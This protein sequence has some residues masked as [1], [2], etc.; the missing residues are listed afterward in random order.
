MALTFA[1]FQF[2]NEPLFRDLIH[3]QCF[4]YDN[5]FLLYS[6]SHKI[7]VHYRT[8]FIRNT[9]IL[10]WARAELCEHVMLKELQ[11]VFVAFARACLAVCSVGFNW[12]VILHSNVNIFLS[13]F[14]LWLNHSVW[15]WLWLFWLVVEVLWSRYN[16]LHKL[17][18]KQNSFVVF[19]LLRQ[20]GAR[21]LY[22]MAT[23]AFAK[24]WI[25]VNILKP[26]W[27]TE[28]CDTTKLFRVHLW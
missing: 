1:K 16:L 24:K 12:C 10:M 2:F 9:S 21:V 18:L 26:V 22:T 27:C 20:R 19:F 4:T 28:R 13:V 7:Y 5:Q 6:L 15:R 25:N 17:P 3:Y 14:L 23:E 11:V 8:Y